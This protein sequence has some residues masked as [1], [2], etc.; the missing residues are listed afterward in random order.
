VNLDLSRYAEAVDAV[1]TITTE[2]R[3]TKVVGTVLEA[4]GPA[5]PVGAIGR[6][7]PA[8]DKSRAVPVEVIGFREDR[9]LLMPLGKAD[10][11]EPGSSVVADRYKAAAGVGGDMLGRVL[12]G[13][14]NPLDGGPGLSPEREMPLYADPVNPLLRAR[15]TEPLD[16]G[17]RSIN[18]LT[19]LAKGQRAAI[20]A[21]S[22]VGKSVLLGMM[23]RYTSA[24][25][26]VIGLIGERGREVREFIE[27]DLGEEGL[28]RS[29]VVV[30]TSDSS[31][32]SRIRGAY[33]ASA[34]AEFFRDRGKDVLLMMD[35][36]TRFAMAAREVGL[37]AGEPPT[38]KA[39]P[40]ST[41][42]HLPRLL[43]RAGTGSG[44]GSITGIYT[45]LVE[46]D[47]MNEPIADAVRSIVDGHIVLDRG[48]ASRGHYPAVDVL[49]SVSRLMSEVASPDHR[50][51]AMEFRGLLADF[52]KIEDLVNVGAYEKG[53]NDRTDHALEMIDELNAFLTQDVETRA[54]MKKSIGEMTKLLTVRNLGRTA[55]ARAR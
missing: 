23:A 49:S 42:A 31:P 13:L 28:G 52:A 37:A 41:F 40:P 46:G 25:V 8:G 6:V 51:R 15:I 47:D 39:Y 11:I 7:V 18:C 27:R 48:L 44:R 45:V 5:M 12:D 10:G 53:V 38:S 54:E 36:V 9:V 33:F 32:L 21:G 3:I 55:K 29:V 17:V 14:G 34:V 4:N 26:N 2:G 24:D 19:T 20:M 22:G 35:S 43:E 30:A 16:V 50:K 1:R